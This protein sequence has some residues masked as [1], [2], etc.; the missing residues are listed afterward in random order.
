MKQMLQAWQKLHNLLNY[1]N[2]KIKKATAEE[3]CG[4]FAG[5]PALTGDS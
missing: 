2:N 3:A 5:H 1:Y 4:L